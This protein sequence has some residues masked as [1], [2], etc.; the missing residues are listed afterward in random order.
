[1]PLLVCNFL[2]YVLYLYKNLGFT[3]SSKKAYKHLALIT[4][5]YEDA[6]LYTI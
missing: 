1:M 5:G 4:F 2:V 3:I 6:F